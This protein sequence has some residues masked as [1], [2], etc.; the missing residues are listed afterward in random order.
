MDEF[1]WL[2]LL[3]FVAAAALALVGAVAGDLIFRAE[4]EG[5]EPARTHHGSRPRRPE[6]KREARLGPKRNGHR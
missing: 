1:A 4:W 5:E 2:V 6:G 3:V